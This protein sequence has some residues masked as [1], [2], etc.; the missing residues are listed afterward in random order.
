MRKYGITKTTVA[1]ALMALIGLCDY[2][3]KDQ[4]V[5]GYPKATA[6]ILT[7]SGIIVVILRVFTSLPILETEDTNAK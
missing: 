1:G 2:L 7:T 6:A 4:F 3:S 5:M